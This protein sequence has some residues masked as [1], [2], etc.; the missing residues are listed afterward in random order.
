[1]QVALD[2]TED[3]YNWLSSESPPSLQGKTPLQLSTLRTF[4]AIF[5]EVFYG[6]TDTQGSSDGLMRIKRVGGQY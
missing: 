4:E 3:L 6:P 1:M 5:G 2:R